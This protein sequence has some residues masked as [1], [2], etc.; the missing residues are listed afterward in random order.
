MYEEGVI[1]LSA[2]VY[3]WIHLLYVLGLA[4]KNLIYTTP[5]GEL[6]HIFIEAVFKSYGNDLYNIFKAPEI[7][8]IKR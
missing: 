6:Q 5:T 7:E 4:E 8:K 2:S 3:S 1:I